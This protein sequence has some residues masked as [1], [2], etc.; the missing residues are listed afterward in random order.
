[1]YSGEIKS[2]LLII[3]YRCKYTQ[4]SLSLRNNKYERP[5]EDDKQ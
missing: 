3:S 2:S 4:F 5:L 1:M